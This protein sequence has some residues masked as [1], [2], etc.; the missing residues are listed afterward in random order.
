MVRTF[1]QLGRPCL[2]IAGLSGSSL[3]RC[4]SVEKA[5]LRKGTASYDLRH[6][7]ASDLRHAGESV[8]VVGD[9][10]GHG[11][12]SLV[13]STHG[14]LMPDSEERTRR[15]STRRGVPPMCLRR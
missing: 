8:A 2:R 6:H 4:G 9:R 15:R 11:N 12:A 13:L 1:G 7:C 14:R 5:V 3:A 10:L